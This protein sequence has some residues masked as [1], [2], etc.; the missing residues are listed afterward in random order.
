M[1]CRKREA[2]P[3]PAAL[4]S[5]LTKTSPM[6]NKKNCLWSLLSLLLAVLTLWAVL[7]QSGD[8]P[9]RQL[10][11]EVR[12]AK[13]GCLAAAVLCGALF[14]FLEGQAIRC[15]LQAAGYRRGFRKG[16][17]YSAADIY[18]SAI[19]P[20]ASGGQPA[21]AL[22]MIR[23]GI[24]S[25][26]VTATLIVNLILYTVSIVFLGVIAALTHPHLFFV[27]RPLSKALILIGAVLLS[28]LTL[29]FFLLLG[30]GEKVFR[31]I[32]TFYRFL[33]RHRYLRR[34]EH[35]LER[36]E[37]A[38]EEYHS[39]IRLVRGKPRLIV[40]AFLYNFAQR[41]A[42]IAV[43]MFVYLAMDGRAGTAFAIFASQCFITIGYNCVPVPGG[44]GVA[45]FL[46][47]DAFSDLMVM[48]D[49]LH[50]E[51]LSRSISFYICVA[52]SGI[53]VLVSTI[54]RRKKRGVGR[55]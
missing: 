25:G 11:T 9:L 54:L 16:T 27:F 10:W 29:V 30:N 26:V 20:S 13:P 17:V 42:Q 46:M 8:M 18:F 44:M 28:A 40:K 31:A 43:P 45:D 2:S 34:L 1:P 39:C 21:S 41:A 23:D 3:L 7:R 35:R 37:Q 52:V 49:A 51:L 36:L 38:E 48:E 24:P 12:E 5:Q 22:Y 14:L 15:L 32:G 55:P 6:N 33:A 19:T 50:L 47:V 53:I 4:C